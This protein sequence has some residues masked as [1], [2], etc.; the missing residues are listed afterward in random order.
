MAPKQP[1]TL[2]LVFQTREEFEREYQSN[3]ANGG[4]FVATD[5][6]FAVRARVTVAIKLLFI[7]KGLTLTGEVVHVVGEELSSSGATPGIA[8]QF[9]AA[10]AELRS[11][12]EP[13]LEAIAEQGTPAAVEPDPQPP[14]IDE[15]HV[16]RGAPRS[17]ARL[18]ARV[19]CPGCEP[20]EG[21]TRDLS[22]TGALVSIGSTPPLDLDEPVKVL[23]AHPETGM[24][25]EILGKVARHVKGEG[26]VVRA[27]GIQF[28]VRDSDR[29]AVEQFLRDLR[30]TEHSRHLGGI[31]GEISELGLANLVQT[32]GVAAREGTLDV[33]CGPE[34]GYLAFEDGCLRAASLGGTRGVKALARMLAWTEGRFEFHARIDP[35]TP[36]DESIPL[37]GAMLEA[38]RLMD[39]SAEIDRAQFPADALLEVD[40]EARSAASELSK[41]EEAVLDLASSNMNVQ[42]ILDIIPETDDEIYLAMWG[43]M[44]QG[45]LR[46]S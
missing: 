12:F 40:E 16:K 34:E 29:R 7:K 14:E 43:L 28:Y 26:D 18:M 15:G 31:Q 4:V 35:A 25:R 33:M 41:L 30:N 22:I 11:V 39:E 10:P 19:Y 13:V 2:D 24:E 20:I 3:I 1:K 32:F 27:I 44:E 45:V 6:R 37:D 46:Q 8:V 17:R 36:R 21:R 42:R 5:E 9:E 38:M 23:I